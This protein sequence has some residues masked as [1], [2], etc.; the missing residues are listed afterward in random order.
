[1]ARKIV[2]AFSLSW[3]RKIELSKAQVN[4]NLPQHSL[5]TVHGGTICTD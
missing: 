5:V 4:L 3:K 2:S 1:V